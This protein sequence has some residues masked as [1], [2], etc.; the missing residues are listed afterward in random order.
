[1]KLLAYLWRNAPTCNHD[2]ETAVRSEIG[3]NGVRSYYW[4]CGRCGKKVYVQ[5]WHG[6]ADGDSRAASHRA[7][8][9]LH[10]A[11]AL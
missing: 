2:S 3:H 8:S 5:D 4:F 7:V 10:N 1:M 11:T 9:E 6:H